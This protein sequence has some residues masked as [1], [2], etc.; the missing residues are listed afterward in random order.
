M[1]AP[2]YRPYYCGPART[3][4]KGGCEKN[5]E[6]IRKLLPKGRGIRLDRLT[7]TDAALVMSQVSSTLT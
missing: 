3:D 7:R 6:E 2:P 5:H 1:S 4:Q